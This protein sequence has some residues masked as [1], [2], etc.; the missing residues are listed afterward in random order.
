MKKDSVSVV[1]PVYGSEAILAKLIDGI[2]TSLKSTEFEVILV[3][4][5][6]PDGSW[7]VIRSLVSENRNIRG[8][9][10]GR[11][12][13]QHNA[14]LAGFAASKFEIVVTM[15]DDLQHNPLEIPLLIKSLE[16]GEFDVAYGNF[17]SREHPYWKK[18]GSWLNNIIASKI[19][20][21]PLSLYLSPFRAIR[22]SIVLEVLKF[23]GPNPYID[24]LL[25]TYT[26]SITSV[27]VS[28]SKRDQ[29]KS[30]YG[31]SKSLQLWVQMLTTTS[32]APLRFA[33][34][35]GMLFSLIA[36]VLGFLLV[37]QKLTL[38][39]MPI[40]WSSIIVTILFTTG[41]QL[42]ALGMI[43]E[44][45]GKVSLTVNQHPQYS[46]RETVG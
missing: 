32:I 21:K 40:G 18:L 8:I 4:D 7:S 38:D 1:I 24:G 25:L 26:R 35:I 45:L 11:N 33:T 34:K 44:Y 37:I 6:S 36:M 2:K 10:L 15:D 19:L 12:F 3:C 5:D 43:G 29:G 13:G 41:I 46:I 17:S 16:S 30:S 22:R 31:F 28:H 20:A 23:K 39:I 42:F 27:G 14:L 9:L